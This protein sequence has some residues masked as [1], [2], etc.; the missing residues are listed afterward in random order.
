MKNIEK[1]NEIFA[2]DN[3]II[4]E[5]ENVYCYKIDERYHIKGFSND[6]LKNKLNKKIWDEDGVWYK[7]VTLIIN[8]NNSVISF[9]GD[10]FHI[11]SFYLKDND[12]YS[13]NELKKMFDSDIIDIYFNLKTLYKRKFIFW[14]KYYEAW[15]PIFDINT[16][17]MTWNGELKVHIPLKSQKTI[18]KVITPPYTIQYK[19]V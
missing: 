12:E 19:G 11:E 2:G 16:K 9:K 1:S 15:K 8:E 4:L 17:L 13:I 6:Y 7:N 5:F 14:K 3:P 10:I 18:H